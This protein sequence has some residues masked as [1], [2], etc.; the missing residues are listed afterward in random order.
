MISIDVL[1]YFVKFM[2]ILISTKC[3]NPISVSAQEGY[4][5][6]HSSNLVMHKFKS[7]PLTTMYKMHQHFATTIT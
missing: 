4:S 1:H 3:I 5:G 7:C 6:Y 2:A